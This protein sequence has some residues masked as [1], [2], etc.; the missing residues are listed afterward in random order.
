MYSK[1]KYE[2]LMYLTPFDDIRQPFLTICFENV[3]RFSC[4]FDFSAKVLP[5]Y[6]GSTIPD[7][8]TK[9]FTLKVD[10]FDLTSMYRS[11]PRCEHLVKMFSSEPRPPTVISTVVAPCVVKQRHKSVYENYRWHFSAIL[12]VYPV[13][14]FIRLMTS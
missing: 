11:L 3:F 13:E 1:K 12:K 9:H 8:D 6:V 14:F 10:L 4:F 2:I 7:I 5:V